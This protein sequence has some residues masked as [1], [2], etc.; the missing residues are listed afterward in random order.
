MK[1][2]VFSDSH[3]YLRTLKSALRA[4]P[5]AE[6]VFFLGDGICDIEEAAYG[7]SRRAYVCVRGNCDTSFTFRESTVKKVETINL[8]GYNIL[9]TH[10]DLYGAKYGMGGLIALGK[11]EGADIVLY[12]H[13]HL[14]HEEYVN[15][16]ERPMYLFNPGSASAIDGSFGIITLG[17]TPLFSH[18]SII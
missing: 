6:V 16:L 9:L 5:D 18:G 17:K 14:P 2:L 4:H 1:C 12:G 15:N 3:G 8:L 7:D 13:T 11:S 10:G